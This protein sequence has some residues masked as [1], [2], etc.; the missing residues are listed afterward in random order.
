MSSTLVATQVVDPL[1]VYVRELRNA[2][3]LTQQQVA[4]HLGLTRRSYVLW[5]TAR[6]NDIKLQ[7]ARA[8]IRLLGGSLQHLEMLDVMQVED[9]RALAR[10]WAAQSEEDRETALRA[11]LKFKRV[12][13]L[14]END[15]ALLEQIVAQ[16]RK[17]ATHDSHLLEMI[18]TFL[19][20]RRSGRSSRE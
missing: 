11:R 1:R 17:D 20:G 9:A 3:G 5:E 19:D 8:L 12:I 18:T 6:T 4:D 13:E 10:E 2:A 16:L 14:G 7:H 15:P